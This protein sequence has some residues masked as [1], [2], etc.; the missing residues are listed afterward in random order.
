[1]K[2]YKIIVCIAVVMCIIAALCPFGAGAV[3]ALSTP[4]Q[5]DFEY[6]FGKYSGASAYA[7]AGYTGD[8]NAVTYGDVTADL[9]AFNY[10]YTKLVNTSRSEF[11]GY[12]YTI[13]EAKAVFGADD[14]GVAAAIEAQAQYFAPKYDNSFRH[15]EGVKDAGGVSRDAW[16]STQFFRKDK[17]TSVKGGISFGIKDASKITENDSE[18][19]FVFEYL[20]NTTE[21]IILSYVNTA[22]TGTEDKFTG[23]SSVIARKGTNRWKTGIIAVNDAKF[24]AECDKRSTRLCSGKEDF[25]F[26]GD[27]LYISS[28]MVIKCSELEELA[29][30]TAVYSGG[31]DAT[32]FNDEIT[33]LYAFGYLYTKLHNPRYDFNGYIYTIDEAKNVYG[34]NDEKVLNAQ[35]EGY[36]YY[37]PRYDNAFRCEKEVADRLGIKKDAW[38][39]TRYWR[40]DVNASRDGGIAFGIKDGSRIKETDRE[41]TFRIEYLDKG[42][43]NITLLYVNSSWTG[44]EDKF[45]GSSVQ[46]KR[47]GSNEWKTAYVSVDDAYFAQES[48]DRKTKLCSSKEDFVISGNDLYV[49]SVSVVKTPLT[50]LVSERYDN[51]PATVYTNRDAVTGR[52]W[53]AMQLPGKRTFRSYVTAQSWNVNGTKFVVSDGTSLYE[54]DT[55]NHT[56][57]FLD[58]GSNNKCYVSPQNDIYYLSGGYANKI[59]W[60]TYQKTVLCKLPDECS[61]LSTI[62]ATDDGR[63]MSG[64]Y[65]GS[66]D[67]SVVRLNT[68]LAMPDYAASKDFS[69]NPH[70]LGVGHPI[71]NPKYENLLFFCHEG[72]TTVIPDRLWVADIQSGVM[73]NVFIQ[74]YN[75]DGTT[76]ECSGHEVWS[77]DG[78]YLY[79]VKYANKQNKGQN[80]LVRIPFKNGKF[81]GE[82]EYINGDAAYW[83]CYPSG[84]N[85]WVVADV[86]TGEVWIA[87]TATHRSY[88]IADFTLVRGERTDPHPHFS[89]ASNTINWDIDFDGDILK[90]G[91]AWADVSDI[92]LAQEYTKTRISTGTNTEA[93]SVT[94]TKSEVSTEVV[95]GKTFVK[96]PSGNKVYINIKDSFAKSVNQNVSVTFTAYSPSAATMSIGYTSP[97]VTDTDWHKYEDSSKTVAIS[98]GT[99]EYTVDF[100][101]INI[102]NINKFATDM[103]F[104]SSLGD[105]YIADVKIKSSSEVTFDKTDGRYISNV[106]TAVQNNKIAF[107]ADAVNNTQL[108][109]NAT[110]Y[111]VVYASDGTLADISV[112]ESAKITSMGKLQLNAAANISSGQTAKVFVLS[113]NLLPYAAPQNDMSVNVTLTDTAATIKWKKYDY[114]Y[115][116]LYKVFCDG[117]QVGATYDTQFTHNTSISDAHTWH[118]EACDVYGNNLWYSIN[119]TVT[120]K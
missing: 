49:H 61:S 98:K 44:T 38:Y 93:V 77:K 118:I 58:Y 97:V 34:K 91:V 42:T 70:T 63:Y 35:K 19:V 29:R 28:V 22:W 64:Y 33:D 117:V 23:S 71:L 113:D 37:A 114:D 16:F 31:Y 102:N 13:D 17:M 68:E 99:G 112:S 18:L 83:H 15:E 74:S 95:E 108:D 45:V 72:T 66:L 86:N 12:I 100:G 40:G 32:Q 90:R 11:N 1:M 119:N 73:Q 67:A 103:F 107:T 62:S 105:T 75:Q 65:S 78:E 81:T 41:L 50:A 111:T 79:F 87:G 54:F 55:L 89:Y 7:V 30:T 46:I 36:S 84:D 106:S 80:G 60:D 69:Y 101:N 25:V 115:Q 85:N 104:T 110:L 59:D 4:E 10:L 92:T 26:K 48:D 5:T 82:R 21:N 51:F 57:R 24:A 56:Y 2:K 9:Y 14:E 109:S 20:D 76:A 88:Q 8:Y 120:L 53:Y 27:D 94:N 47:T 3:C 52:I 116:V 43:E 96:A 39:C 6:F